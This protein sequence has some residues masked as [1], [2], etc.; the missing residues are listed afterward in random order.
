MKN[1]NDEKKKRKIALLQ[2]LITQV[3]Q[4]RS[5][6]NIIIKNIVMLNTNAGR[7]IK[8]Y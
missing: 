8:Q 7:T 2:T 6:L 1:E 3:W 5:K 4:I